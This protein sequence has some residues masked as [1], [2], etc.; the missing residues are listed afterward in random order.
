MKR[1]PLIILLA[2]CS[3]GGEPYTPP[4]A[5]FSVVDVTRDA[6]TI[7]SDADPDDPAIVAEAQRQCGL[8][9]RSATYSSSHDSDEVDRMA[10]ALVGMTGAGH[11]IYVS[12]HIFVCR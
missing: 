5:D 2:G 8:F 12:D 6:V 10:T 9:G 7:R 3:A 1:L 4:P 11:P